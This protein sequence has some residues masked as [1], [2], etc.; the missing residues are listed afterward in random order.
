[1]DNEQ[2][3]NTE[4][5][6]QQSQSTSKPQTQNTNHSQQGPQT[7]EPN[8][9]DEKLQ[10]PGT[11]KQVVFWL[12]VVAGIVADLWTKH[13]VFAWLSEKPNYEYTV[14]EGFLTIVMRQND[15][16]AFS[17]FSGQRVLLT[18]ISIVA[19]VFVVGNFYFGN[20]KSKLLRIALAMFTAG[21]AGNLYDRIFNNGLV[22]DFIDIVYWPGKHWP[23]FNVA[24]SLLCTAVGLIIISFFITSFQHH[25]NEEQN[26]NTDQ[27]P[28]G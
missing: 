21:I 13:A 8:R 1:M 20:I 17:I 2:A 18:V 22:R 9:G 27:S 12:I 16:A 10:L 25:P 5:L 4:Q 14:V 11:V 3:K 6:P 23:A 7:D 26:P 15:G 19:L 28:A 24:D